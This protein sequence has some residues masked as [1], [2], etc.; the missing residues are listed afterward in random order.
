MLFFNEVDGRCPI[1]GDVLTHRKG[2]KIYKTFEV[3]H[4][5]PANPRSS[6]IELLKNELRLSEDVNDLK[7]AF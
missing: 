6:E 4:I 1:C 3:A 2:G 7:Y 5:Y